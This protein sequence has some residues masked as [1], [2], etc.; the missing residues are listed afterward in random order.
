MASILL[1][2]FLSYL[3]ISEIPPP[4]LSLSQSQSN[5]QNLLFHSF[6]SSISIL[7]CLLLHVLFAWYVLAALRHLPFLARGLFCFVYGIGCYIVARSRFEQEVAVGRLGMA[8]SYACG[9]FVSLQHTAP[10]HSSC[11]ILLIYK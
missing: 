7:L 3:A 9:V 1:Y 10:L 5:L 6:I 4:H 2:F 11:P 8:G